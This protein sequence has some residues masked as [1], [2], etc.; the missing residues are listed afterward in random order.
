M[1]QS[2]YLRCLRRVAV[3]AGPALLAGCTSLPQW[4]SNGLKVG[5]NF[6]EPPAVV[7]PAWIEAAQPQIVSEPA[8]TDA[9]W[10]IF[11]DPDLTR[12]IE[13]AYRQNLDLKTAASRVLQA[14]AQRNITAGN[15]FPQTQNL[16]ADYA[17][18][19][20]SKNLA[21]FSSPLG[22]FPSTLD[23]WATGFNASWELDLW[24]RLRRAIESADAELGASVEAYHDALVTLLADVA[25]SYVQLRTF[26]QRIAY[27]RR[28]V[29]LQRGTLQLA[30]ARLREGKATS[31]DVMQ[32]RSSLAQTQALIPPLVIGLR[33]AN[34]RLCLLLGLPPEDLT[35]KLAEAPIPVTPAEAAVG[36]P[37]DLLERRPDVR[38]ARLEVAAQSAQIG[39]AEAD[40][41]PQIGVTGFL[42]YAA[43]DLRLLFT[44]N[45]FTGLILPSVQ[46]KILNYGRIRNNVRLQD[47]RLQ[48]KVLQYQKTVLTA[49]REV[50]DALA[51]FLQYQLQARR[52]AESV[53]QAEDA[54]E[55]VQAQYKAGLVDFNRV[56]TTQAQLL[57]QEDQLAV[58]RGNI[59]VSL[60]AVY[61]ALGGGWQSPPACLPPQKPPADAEIKIKSAPA[62]PPAHLGHPAGVE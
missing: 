22:G 20:L 37:A 29:A 16:L 18:A 12:L 53:K 7:A 6:H 41:Y 31:L 54:V 50:E 58:A 44:P 21:L 32:A 30:E 34:D 40:F 10:T 36:I 3:L 13:T 8:D 25:T 39:V 19:Q 56:F 11:Q 1:G 35:R 27:A 57:T 55:L 61:R 62:P 2:L 4:L 47:V 17:H 38:R 26:Q 45:S 33:Q 51:A 46:W 42:G 9:W 59:A 60:I 23:V 14:Q 52:L 5:P 15:L 28:N 43:D 24:G 49:G 48:E